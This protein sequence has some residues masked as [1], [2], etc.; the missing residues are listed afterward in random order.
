[1]TT[2]LTP[3]A[4]R[5][6]SI[7]VQQVVEMQIPFLPPSV[8]L[9]DA[10]NDLVDALRPRFEPW[11]L[12]PDTGKLIFAIQTY[13]IRTSKH[14]IL[15]DTCVGC[16]KDSSMDFWH[17]REDRV[18]LQRL[19]ATGVSPE[20][21]DYVFCTHLHGDHIGWNTQLI[22]GQFVP[23]FP[24][25]KYIFSQAEVEHASNAETARMPAWEQSVLPILEAGQA[26]LVET[27]FALDDE[28]W[29]SPTPGHT[30]GHV[31]VHLLSGGQHAV[32]VG[33]AIHSPLQCAHPEWSA[34]PDTDK[35]LSART[36]IKL[37][38]NCLSENHLVLPAH[39]PLPSVG[40][41][42]AADQG[43]GFNFKRPD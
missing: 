37:L 3:P 42:I 5:I 4:F 36:R 12:C 17:Q 27:D 21:I 8:F 40:H 16:N 25:A 1:M 34:R 18:W 19:I 32:L 38:E 10:P 30:P 11:A 15:V 33:D 23:T 7:S 22:D 24:N 29:L 6:G 13:V 9:P 14:T 43:F 31:A 28:I 41:V 26:Q 35:A 20:D 39:F 2:N